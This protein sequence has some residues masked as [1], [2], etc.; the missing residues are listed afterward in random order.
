LAFEEALGHDRGSFDDKPVFMAR[1]ADQIGGHVEKPSR[2]AA[3]IRKRPRLA[4]LVSALVLG[5][6]AAA[7]AL[8]F[9]RMH[10]LGEESPTAMATSVRIPRTIGPP[11]AA[12]AEAPA[13]EGKSELADSPAVVSRDLPVLVAPKA[14]LAPPPPAGG[15]T[16]K[17]APSN[18]KPLDPSSIL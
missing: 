14:V 9:P 4:L 5:A 15:Q 11:P 16:P 12:A 17:S 1:D 2:S 3:I 6:T 13:Q 8:S 18:A 10:A 7:A